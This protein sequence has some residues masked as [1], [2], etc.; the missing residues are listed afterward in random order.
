MMTGKRK[1]GILLPITALPARHGIGTLGKEAFAFA[2]FLSSCGCSIWQILP[3]CV[4]SYGNS[5]YQSPSSKGL[6]YYLIDLDFLVEKGLLKEEEIIDLAKENPRKVDYGFLFDNRLSIL[7][8]AFARFDKKDP[9]FVAF[10]KKGVYDDFSFYMAMKDI[11]SFRPWYEWPEPF[12]HYSKEVEEMVKKEHKDLYLF[13]QWTQFEFLDQFRKLKKYVHEKGIQLM[14][15]LPLYLSYDSVECYKYPQY[16]QLDESHRPTVVAGCPP[17]YFSPLGQL[18]GN[19]IYDWKRLKEDNY[20][21]FDER[22][23]YAMKFFDI[24]RLDHFRGFSAYYSIPY[25]RED[26]VIGKWVKGPGIDFFKDKKHLPIVAEDLGLLDE[27]VYTLLRESTYP[28]MRVV[29]FGMDGKKD[30]DHFPLNIPEKC[31][32]YSGTH[33]NMPLLG[34]L[35]DLDEEAL[36]DYEKSAT[37]LVSHYGLKEKGETLKDLVN[38]TLEGLFACKAMTAI[39][40]IQD[41]LCLGKESRMNEPSVL[42]YRNWTF[43][44]VAEDF[45]EKLLWKVRYLRC[46][47]KPRDVEEGK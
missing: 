14:G 12:C 3:L 25:G 28:G 34:F 31:F 2:D 36:A 6:N 37:W 47:G 15:D 16:F 11:H 4:T 10:L 44:C 23:S 8:K 27:D 45:D 7:K 29:E 22:I 21:F 38:I 18:W 20:A 35:E 30:N 17:D 39:A 19:P 46:L 43:R 32:A 33:D 41:L 13:Y 40:P 1:S 9:E 26:A 42:S 5:P 24:I